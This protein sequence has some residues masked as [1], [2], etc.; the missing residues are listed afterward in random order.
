MEIFS[1]SYGY[2]LLSIS[3][4]LH[5]LSLTIVVTRI[6]TYLVNVWIQYSVNNQRL[7]PFVYLVYHAYLSYGF[8]E[9]TNS[10]FQYCSYPHQAVHCLEL[11]SLDLYLLVVNLQLNILFKRR[12]SIFYCISLCE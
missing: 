9:S 10:I 4:F 1:L 11:T 8:M 7:V 6:S 5:S 3:F 12:N 2:S